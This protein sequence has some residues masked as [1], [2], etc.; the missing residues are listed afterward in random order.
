M[1]NQFIVVYN[2]NVEIIV[3][4]LSTRRL[5]L[6]TII[7]LIQFSFCQNLPFYSLYIANSLAELEYSYRIA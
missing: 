2:Q 4:S 6:E 3:L 5:K 7:F 1:I